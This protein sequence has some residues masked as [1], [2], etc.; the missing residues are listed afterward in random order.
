MNA[1]GA[2]YADAQL[3]VMKPREAMRSALLST[4]DMK[5]EED[6]STPSRVARRT[7]GLASPGNAGRDDETGTRG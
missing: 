5:V 2:S 3:D 7:E 4:V 6:V 1:L